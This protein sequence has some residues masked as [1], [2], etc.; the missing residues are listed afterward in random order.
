V[1]CGAALAGLAG[2]VVLMSRKSS[3]GGL[4]NLGRKPSTI[5][6]LGRTAKAIDK[7]GSKVGELTAEVR[8][9]R[10]EIKD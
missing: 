3:G 6:L 10:E 4:P 7:T 8:K 1:A 5:K 2:G 9:V